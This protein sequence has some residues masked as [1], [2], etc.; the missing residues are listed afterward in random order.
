M[1]QY[2]LKFILLQSYFILFHLSGRLYFRSRLQVYL[3]PDYLESVA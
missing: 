3:V 1:L 2:L